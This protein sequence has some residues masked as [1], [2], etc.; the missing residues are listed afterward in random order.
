M[1][2]RVGLTHRTTYKYDKTIMMGPQTLRLRPAPHARTPIVS[3]SQS[4]TPHD[5]FLNWQQDPFG[6]YQ[7]RAVFPNPTDRFEVV[8]DLVADMVAINPFDFFLDDDAFHAPF[9]YEES[10]LKDLAPYLIAP[11]GGERFVGMAKATE[12]IWRHGGKEH[13]TIDALVEINRMVEQ[14]IDYTVRMEPGVQTPEDTLKLARGS[15]RDSSWLLVNLLRHVGVASRFVSGYLIQLAPDEKPLEGPSGPEEDFTD[16][17][18]WVEAFVPGAGWIGLDPTSGLFASEGHIPLAATPTPRSAAPITGGVEPCEVEFEFDMKVERLR[19]PARISLPFTET[20]WA[21]IDHAGQI[22]D[23]VLEANDIRLTMGGEPTFVAADDRDADEWTIDAVGPTKRIYADKLAR[24]MRDRF[25]PGGLLTHGQGKWYPGEPLPRWAFG[26]VWRKDGEPLWRNADLIAEETLETPSTVDDAQTFTTALCNALDVAPE[27]AQ[28]AYEDPSRYLLQ[29][30]QLPENL[31][32]ADNNLD[33]PVDRRRLAR[34]FEQGLTAPSAYVLPLQQLQADGTTSRAVKWMSE[35]WRTRRERLLLIPGDSPAGFRLPMKSL[36][37]IASVDYR[38]GYPADPMEERPALPKM[39]PRKVTKEAPNEPLPIG[40]APVR[41]ALVI[42]PRDGFLNVFLPP[43]ISAEAY[44]DLI[45]SVEAAVEAAG[46][47]V[48]LE[49]Y[50]PPSDPRFGEIKVTPDPGVIEVNIHPSADWNDLRDKTEILYEEARAIGLDASGFMVDGRPIGSG[51][52]AHVTVGGATAFESPFLRRPDVLGSLIRFWQN[53]PSLSY[54]FSGLSLG[55][56]SQAPRADEAR[57]DILYDLEI[58]LDQ[59]PGPN[60]T[61]FPPWLVDRVLRHLL[62]D[63]TGNT[64]RAEICI[65]KLYS[66]DG[67]AGRLGLVEF[68][69]FEMPPHWRMNVAQQ[70]VIRSL[71]AWFWQEPYRE[72]LVE[73]GTALHDRFMLPDVLWADFGK[74]LDKISRGLGLRLE[75]E[76]FRAQ[77]DF[78]FPLAGQIEQDGTTFELRSALEPWHVLGEE[79]TAGGTARFVDASVERLQVKLTGSF[80]G[81]ALGV[82]CNGRLLPL[83]PGELSAEKIAGVRF[84]TWLPASALHPTIQ[85]HGPLVF[86]LV[87]LNAGRAIGGCTYHP[88][89]P[90]GRNFETRPINAL[91]AEG[92]RLARFQPFGHSAPGTVFTPANPDPRCPF[93]LDLRRR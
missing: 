63:V 84:R 34:V 90:G 92:R 1:T 12:Q 4:I 33:D 10:L 30:A 50:P 22:V 79:G 56:T 29:E 19:E 36:P 57:S 74:V 80:N 21:Q 35:I 15:C 89:H 49:G 24:R 88:T 28:P 61:D 76:W 64:H 41:T 71:I 69:A 7:A 82:A 2:I 86:D 83:Q 60:D 70:L 37:H 32:P 75:R 66:P 54:F 44:L 5:H 9:T 78:R 51:G 62:V 40:T 65:D 85:P 93:T 55:P 14:A 26:I 47:P 91:E 45:A 3:Y 52:G 59:L 87:D 27:H 67:P 39:Q 38:H 8:V 18:A 31:T 72:R 17:H 73:Y 48:R 46:L 77:F 11:E 20:V 42:E 68:R 43:T 6:N 25:A 81:E 23:Q 16:L 13:Q 53:H 58:A